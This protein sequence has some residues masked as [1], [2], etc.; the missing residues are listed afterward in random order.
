MDNLS[1]QLNNPPYISCSH[2]SCSLKEMQTYKI[3]YAVLECSEQLYK[4]F[5]EYYRNNWLDFKMSRKHLFNKISEGIAKIQDV[6]TALD[7][8]NL[9]FDY[10]LEKDFFVFNKNGKQIHKY[11]NFDDYVKKNKKCTRWVDDFDKGDISIRNFIKVIVELGWNI[12]FVFRE[13]AN[14]ED[15]E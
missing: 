11:K 1:Y 10:C 7:E 12:N 9:S 2:A 8:I 4:A 6:Q 15:Q 14:K 3:E 5:G 13:K